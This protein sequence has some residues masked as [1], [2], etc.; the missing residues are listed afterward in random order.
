ML[1]ID[2]IDTKKEIEEYSFALKCREP[3]GVWGSLLA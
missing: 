3:Q 1:N 2:W